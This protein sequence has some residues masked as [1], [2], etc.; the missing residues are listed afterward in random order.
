MENVFWSCLFKLG[1]P[2]EAN[3][4]WVVGTVFVDMVAG[5]QQL[6]VVRGPVQ[7]GHTTTPGPPLVHKHP[8]QR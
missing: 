4:V 5:Q 2:D 6:R 3:A 8:I 7:R 1:I